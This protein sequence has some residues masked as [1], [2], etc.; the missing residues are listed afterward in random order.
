[1]HKNLADWLQAIITVHLRK[2]LDHNWAFCH[3]GS[4]GEVQANWSAG[5]LSFEPEMDLKDDSSERRNGGPQI[6]VAPP[7]SLLSKEDMAKLQK[8]YDRTLSMEEQA[9]FCAP[10]LCD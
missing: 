10:F 9:S 2:S 1:M 3:Y 7:P 4:G 5:K 6:T 8:T